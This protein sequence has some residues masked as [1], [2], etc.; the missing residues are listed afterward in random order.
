M[1]AWTADY[2]R[3]RIAECE[4]SAETAVARLEPP[5][6]IEGMRKGIEMLYKWLE[7]AEREEQGHGRHDGDS[8]E[9]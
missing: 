3:K 2:L 1:S 8:Q 4:L 7:Q 6:R 5:A 9:H